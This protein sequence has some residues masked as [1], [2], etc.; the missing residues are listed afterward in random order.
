MTGTIATTGAQDYRTQLRFERPPDVVY[1]ALTT[2][3]GLAGWWTT[4]VSGDGAGGGELR[5]AFHNSDYEQVTLAVETAERPHTVVWSVLAAPAVPAWAEWPG[6]RIA[7]R[8]RP[9]G[10][11]RTTMDLHHEGL[12]PRLHCYDLCSGGWDYV[13]ASLHAYVDGGTGRPIS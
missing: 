6:T 3:P 4:R 1:D 11:G 10:A 8:L 13:L 12:T 2:V 9:D 5:I 7:I